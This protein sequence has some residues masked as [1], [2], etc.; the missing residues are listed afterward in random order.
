M[1]GHAV[2]TGSVLKNLK[3]YY[4]MYV[5]ILSLDDLG[6]GSENISTLLQP[7]YYHLLFHSPSPS[8]QSTIRQKDT[9]PLS[10][11][12]SLLRPTRAFVRTV[13]P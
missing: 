9:E 7:L 6:F 11:W 12:S 10:G 1:G 2:M 4:C 5:C 3:F 8:H 13:Q